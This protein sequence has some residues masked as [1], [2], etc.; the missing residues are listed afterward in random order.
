VK[1]TES[2]V[3]HVEL[4][5]ATKLSMVLPP[6]TFFL[7]SL[8]SQRP[9]SHIWYGSGFKTVGEEHGGDLQGKVNLVVVV[10]VAGRVLWFHKIFLRCDSEP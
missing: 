4:P 6:K 7:M 5:M 8:P 10:V 3:A 9:V 2:N 1:I